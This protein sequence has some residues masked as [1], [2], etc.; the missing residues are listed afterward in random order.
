VLGAGLVLLGLLILLSG[1][2][3]IQGNKPFTISSPDFKDGG[4]LPHDSSFNMNGCTGRNIA[5][6]FRWSGVPDGTQS[7]ALTINDVDAPVAGGFHHWVVFN[8]P[9]SVHELG[10]Q[11]PFDQGTN[12]SGMVGYHGP[13]PPANGQIHHYIISVY[14]LSVPHIAGDSSLTYEALLQAIS[15]DVVGITSTVGTFSRK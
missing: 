3:L 11:P 15:N 4:R 1:S 6:T 5:P 7:F 14:A 12:S 8:I 13:C 10:N 9:A 2:A